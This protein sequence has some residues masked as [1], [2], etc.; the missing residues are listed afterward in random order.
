MRLKPARSRNTALWRCTQLLNQLA[1]DA[2]VYQ[3][4]QC[5]PNRQS[6]VLLILLT[7]FFSIV[8]SFFPTLD[9]WVT[10]SRRLAGAQLADGLM[11]AEYLE[12][13]QRVSEMTV[14]LSATGRDE[15]LEACFNLSVEHLQE[16]FRPLYHSLGIFPEDVWIP[17]Q[18]VVRL[19][20]QLGASS[21]HTKRLIIDLGR[22]A[23]VERDVENHV[24]Q[25]QNLLHDYNREKLGD[26]YVAC[27]GDTATR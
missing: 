5:N 12:I 11:C 9:L 25:L 21:G 1:D 20:T 7:C 3:P 23:L 13:F 8:H 17:E 22:L 6:F 26:A 10:Y 24:L 2:T 16:Q 27:I 14:E 15:N 4:I 19:W 18:V